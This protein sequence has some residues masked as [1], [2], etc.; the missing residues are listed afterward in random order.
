MSTNNFCKVNARN[1]YVVG[2][3]YE[4]EDPE[5]GEPVMREWDEADWEDHKDNFPHFVAEY[6]GQKP[7]WCAPEPNWSQRYNPPYGHTQ[8][9]SVS[10]KQDAFVN[11]ESGKAYKF[12]VRLSFYRIGAYSSN[13]ATLDWDFG[14]DA[15]F[16][17]DAMYLS[18]YRS[19]Y[20]FIDE[21]EDFFWME[22]GNGI[23]FERMPFFEYRNGRLYLGT[24]LAHSR[25]FRQYL[26]KVCGAVIE[27]AEA[28]C[29]QLS[30]T[31]LQCIA[32]LDNGQALYGKA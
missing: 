14:I 1:Y 3:P 4:C 9:A 24:R 7:E 11:P 20:D 30:S 10:L 5:T 19:I 21:A 6:F 28:L 26:K 23:T 12:E 32:Q 15:D 22:N 25:A 31:A 8:L 17:G 29:A 27:K 16:L 13:E 2:E 18:D